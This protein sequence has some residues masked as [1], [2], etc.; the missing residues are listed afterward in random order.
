MRLITYSTKYNEDRTVHLVKE[1]AKNYGKSTVIDSIEKAAEILQYLFDAGNLPE[2]RI[3][4]LALDGSRKV[5]GAFVVSQGTLNASIVHPREIFTRAI[6]AGA[7]SI[8]LAHNHPSGS[9]DISNKDK[10]VSRRIKEAGDIM[11]IGLD[12]HI[13]I[14]END[15][16]SAM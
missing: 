10:E 9:L 6:L 2:E 5:A 7:S 4:L 3:W 16:V 14:A 1:S 8:I 15:F 12:D 13:I 11:G